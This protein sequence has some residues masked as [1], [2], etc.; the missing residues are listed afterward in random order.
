MGLKHIEGKVICQIDLEGKN[1][2][3][4]SDG[5]KIRRERQYDNLNRRETEPVNAVCISSAYIPTGTEIL[6]HA[7]AATETNLINNYAPISGQETSSEIKYYSIPEEQCFI[8]KNEKNEWLPLPP[9]ETA[10]RVFKPYRG[11]I[12]GIE[13]TLIKDVLYVTSGE[14]KGKVVKTLKACDYQIVFQDITGQEGNIIRFRPFGDP[15]TNREEEAIAIMDEMTEQVE[16]GD[17]LVGYAV[18]DAQSIQKG[19]YAD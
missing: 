1:W 12:Q 4:F 14:L 9:Y 7:N 8:W 16:A 13:P 10:L 18:S 2:H 6:V 15:K 11:V 5:T 3:T 19:A 17:L